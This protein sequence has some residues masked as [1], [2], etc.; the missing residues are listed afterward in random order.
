MKQDEQQ[1]IFHQ[2]LT[3]HK[4]LLFK[5]I[6]AYA[7]QAV[8]K[9]DLFQNIS[10]Q[11]WRSIPAYRKEAKVSTWIYRIAL[12]TAIKWLRQS[13]RHQRTHEPLEQMPQLL[14]HTDYQ[15]DERLSWL[16]EE[17]ARLD[18]IDRSLCLLMLDGYSYKE[19][20]EI[21]GLSVSHVGVKINRIK[22]QLMERAKKLERHGV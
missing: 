18:E 21:S 8:D 19:M 15:L 22:K 13:K 20:A 4:G 6:H 3:E 12:N 1:Q 10:L 17:I 14:Q 7:F 9:E 5:V 11:L 2:W 16:Y